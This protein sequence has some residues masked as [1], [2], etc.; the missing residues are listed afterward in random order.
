MWGRTSREQPI[1][2][3]LEL[4]AHHWFERRARSRISGRP[5]CETLLATPK[6]TPSETS[7]DLRHK[8]IEKVLTAS[9]P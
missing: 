8:H 7:C 3:V 2:L 4:H 6:D 5:S 1:G 9:L